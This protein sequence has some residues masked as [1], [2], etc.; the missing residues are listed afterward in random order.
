MC[1]PAEVLCKNLPIEF[2]TYI[3]YC[4]ALKFEEKADYAYLRRLLKDV[5]L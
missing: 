2:S 5:F 4:R 3:D 1:T